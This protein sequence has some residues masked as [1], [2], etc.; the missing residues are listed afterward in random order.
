MFADTK[1][2]EEIKQALLQQPDRPESLMEGQAGLACFLGTLLEGP[3]AVCLARC[4]EAA[5]PWL[6]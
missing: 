2:A 4:N 1:E 6:M 5:S 3:D